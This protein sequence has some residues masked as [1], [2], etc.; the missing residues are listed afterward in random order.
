MAIE[1]E[2]VELLTG[3]AG[4]GSMVSER[5]YPLVL[6]QNPALPA[7]VYQELRGSARTMADGDAGE[8][9]ERFLLSW[10]ASS[11][12]AIKV[13]QMLLVGLLSGYQGG[14]FGRIAVD[15]MRDDYEPE[16]G[17][18]RQQVEILVLWIE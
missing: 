8:H 11:Y 13:G 15:V 9:E 2:L 18:W 7:I 17:R 6:P 5:V 14:H 3:D 12:A 16:T 10:W 1:T 4:I